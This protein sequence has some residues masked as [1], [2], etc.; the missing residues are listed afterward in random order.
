[1]RQIFATGLNRHV[2]AVGFGCASL[3]SRVPAPDGRRAL[4]LAF[5]EGITWFD[6]APPYGDG[7][8]EAILGEF[9]SGKRDQVAICTKVGIEAPHLS[10]PARLAKPALRTVLKLAP[11]LRKQI[12]RHRPA[13]SRAPL[14][15]AQIEGSVTA[16]LKRLKIDYVDVLAL[17]DPSEVD[18][19]NDEV[20]AALS[21]I[22]EK[23]YARVVGI[24]GERAVAENGLRSNSLYGMTQYASEPLTASSFERPILRVTHSVFG[25]GGALSN[26]TAAL[27]DNP[28]ILGKLRDLGLSGTYNQIAATA[29]MQLALSSNSQGVV[30][31]SMFRRDHLQFNVAQASGVPNEH[32]VALLADFAQQ[33]R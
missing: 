7:R 22:I 19:I 14:N 17:H 25:V 27:A 16:S 5:A 32:L 12:A 3:G 13:S 18:V 8:A 28:V 1:M 11:H 9:L 23:G 31:A 6:V 33:I 20:L 30:L 24:A 4:D 21:R 2:S 26:L 29:L 15:A 10:L